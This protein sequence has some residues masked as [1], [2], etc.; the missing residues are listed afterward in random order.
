[1]SFMLLGI[2]NSQ[3]AGGGAGP[4]DFDLLST[5]SLTSSS[6]TIT[7]TGLQSFTDYKH[8]QLR[9]VVH[10][11]GAHDESDWYFR[12]NGDSAASYT[13]RAVRTV[14]FSPTAVSHTYST[15]TEMAIF[16]G[17]L[18][19]NQGT[20]AFSMAVMDIYDFRTNSKNQSFRS[21][22]GHS[23]STHDQVGM[24]SSMYGETNAAVNS[25]STFLQ[26]SRS[27]A[28]GSRFSLYGIKG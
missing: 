16:S 4:T 24:A 25:I 5:T 6:S 20:G 2:L 8:L 10:G 15:G 7:F 1:M 27:F 21:M 9:M 22:M 13:R 26:S 23:G 12:V 14:G 18:G 17:V 11:V 28:A 3:A 19:D